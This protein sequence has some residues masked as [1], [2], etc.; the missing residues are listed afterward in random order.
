[1]RI[2]THQELQNVNGGY[3]LTGFNWGAAIGTIACAAFTG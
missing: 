3:A 2:L 1:M